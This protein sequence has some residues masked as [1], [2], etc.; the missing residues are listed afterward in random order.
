MTNK[1]LKKEIDQFYIKNGYDLDGIMQLLARH[2]DDLDKLLKK[3]IR[4]AMSIDKPNKSFYIGG[5]ERARYLLTKSSQGEIIKE[6][7]Q[8]IKRVRSDLRKK[9][10]DVYRR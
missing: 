3:E 1:Q 4:V 5:L 8:N 6:S 2:R 7:I 10:P 9:Y